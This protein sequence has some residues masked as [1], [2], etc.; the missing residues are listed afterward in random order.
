MCVMSYQGSET[1]VVPGEYAIANT[2]ISSWVDGEA[3]LEGAAAAM[4]H[5]TQQANS[6]KLG[7]LAGALVLG[8]LLGVVATRAGAR[9]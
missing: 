3:A 1:A 7:G 2:L 5:D 9:L 6:R 4:K 8:F